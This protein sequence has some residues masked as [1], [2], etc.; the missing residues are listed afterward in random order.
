MLRSRRNLPWVTGKIRQL[1]KRRDRLHRKAN[2]LKKQSDPIPLTM[3]DKLHSLKKLIQAETRKAYWTHLESLFTPDDSTDEYASMK[4]F[5]KFVKNSRSDNSGIPTLKENGQT[6]TRSRDKAEVLNNQFKRVFTT[7]TDPPPDLLPEVS[8][9]DSMPEINI[10][11]EG[12]K[13]MLDKLKAGK[14]PGPDGIPALPEDI[15]QHGG[16]RPV[17]DFPT[18]I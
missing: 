9:F 16:S 12:I 1:I 17:P 11:T 3:E 10:T 6:V 7:E 4:R 15:V 13:R 14:A 18:L 2:K 5:W 8:P